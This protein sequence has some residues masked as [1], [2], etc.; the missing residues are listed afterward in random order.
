M[1]SQN[2][3]GDSEHHAQI[4]VPALHNLRT[5]VTPHDDSS[6]LREFKPF[7]IGSGVLHVLPEAILVLRLS[8]L[9]I[10]ISRGIVSARKGVRHALFS[11]ELQVRQEEQAHRVGSVQPQ[12]RTGTA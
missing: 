5:T 8:W 3:R 4:F 6:N 12:D 2:P 9:N 7:Q 1:L 10:C 11:D